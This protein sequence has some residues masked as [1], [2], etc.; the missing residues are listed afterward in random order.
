M[1]IAELRTAISDMRGQY[2]F[3]GLAP[4]AYRI[5]GTLEYLSPDVAIMDA[6]GA[7]LVTVDAHSELSQDLEMFVIR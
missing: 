7:Q 6:S 2:R 3:D 4:G 5:L 1:R